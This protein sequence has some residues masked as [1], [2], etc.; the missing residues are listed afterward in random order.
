MDHISTISI[1]GDSTFALCIE[2]Q[3]RGF[4]LFH[5]TPDRLQMRARKVKARIEPLEVRDTVGDHFTLGD[6]VLTDLSE[7]DVILLRQDPPFDQPSGFSPYKR[8]KISMAFCRC[9]RSTCS[10]VSW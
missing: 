7:L 9:S 10:G 5:F 3:N 8:W 2:A 4:D 1:R 6:A